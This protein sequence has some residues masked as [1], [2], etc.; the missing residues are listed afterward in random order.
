MDLKTLKE[1]SNKVEADL[2][3]K[4]REE[5]E[6]EKKEMFTDSENSDLPLDAPMEDDG[7]LDELFGNSSGSDGDDLT[8]APIPP[9]AV[10]N[11]PSGPAVEQP[12][13]QAPPQ[14]KKPDKSEIFFREL[15]EKTDEINETIEMYLPEE[16]GYQRT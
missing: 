7:I 12:V 10:Q 13:Q 9:G 5:E 1:L 8:A 16:T 6:E 15:K 14:P 3:R 2:A 4:K 11:N